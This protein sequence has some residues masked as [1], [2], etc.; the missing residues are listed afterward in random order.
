MNH[1]S[2]LHIRIQPYQQS[3]YTDGLH[4]QARG[5]QRDYIAPNL[6][7][8]IDR[9]NINGTEISAVYL[10]AH[11]AQPFMFR[12]GYHFFNQESFYS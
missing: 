12:R 4:W 8:K 9:Y 6:D 11:L 1:S 5:C 3:P 7:G 2:L 10:C